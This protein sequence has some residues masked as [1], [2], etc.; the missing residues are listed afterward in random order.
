MRNTKYENNFQDY[1]TALKH[2]P[3]R[4]PPSFFGLPDNIH[5][6]WDI[7]AS[8]LVILKLKSLSLPHNII[9]KLDR[10]IWQRGLSPLIGLWKK[11]NQGLDFVRVVLVP[12]KNKKSI[13]ETFIMEEF[14]ECVDLVQKIHKNLA[15][16]NK[17]C[18]GLAST[19]EDDLYDL[20][21]SLLNYKV[22]RKI[23]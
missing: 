23:N 1:M 4:D 20:G 15:G 21:N 18:K 16:L 14:Y 12:E 10:E 13:V 5:R 22:G 8:N 6:A 2:L 3:L 7:Q 9:S 11:I 19:E 17:I